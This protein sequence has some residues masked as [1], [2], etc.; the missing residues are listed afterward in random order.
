MDIN[1]L[2]KIAKLANLKIDESKSE[3]YL[4]QMN[5]IFNLFKTLDEVDT[6]NIEF[7]SFPEV[8]RLRDDV[9]F[10]S[11]TQT[12]ALSQSNNIK[13]NGFSTTSVLGKAT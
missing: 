7:L 9:V 3:K 10:E 6:T 2:N 8:N 1:T 4:A 11:L 5:D 13:N 12:Q